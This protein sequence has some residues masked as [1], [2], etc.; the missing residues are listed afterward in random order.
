MGSVA[1]QLATLNQ[2]HSFIGSK[3][4]QLRSNFPMRR[5]VD[6]CGVSNRGKSLGL[7]VVVAVNGRRGG[8]G[9]QRHV[10]K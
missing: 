3:Q 10:E 9:G 6:M 5:A 8:D 4:D 1:S 7:A 2:L